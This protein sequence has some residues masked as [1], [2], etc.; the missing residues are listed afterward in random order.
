MRTLIF[1]ILV[2]VF[3]NTI[4][5]QIP[6]SLNYQA[7]ARNNQGVA[8]S[9]QTIRIRL[10]IVRGFNTLYT[11]TRQVTTNLL[12]LFNVQIGSPGATSTSG[13]FGDINWAANTPNPT[14]L[15]VE[16]DLTNTN[17][18]TDMGTQ[19]FNTVPTSFW[20]GKSIEVVNL[21]GRYIDP[22]TVPSVNSKLVWNGYAWTPTKN[23]TTIYHTGLAINLPAGGGSAPW[24][25]VAT[26][27]SGSGLPTVTVTGTEKII[28]NW[29]AALGHAYSNF[30]PILAD[31]CY[32]Q[33]PSGSITSFSSF[34]NL[35]FPL[36]IP[37]NTT[38]P[39]TSV[40]VNGSA[41]LTAGQYRVGMCVKNINGTG[42]SLNNNGVFT[43]VV[44][45]KY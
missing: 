23:D 17:I 4:Y 42:A 21:A 34:H 45:V 19:V 38:A 6:Q 32:Q 2:L 30:I 1:L 3:T 13:V 8:L 11:E 40:S 24:T 25:W 9:N 16:L 44:Q 26:N 31:V 5:A 37:I 35:S 39:L 15:K 43:G 33:L 14:M 36:G 41:V 20:S 12:G 27:T 22:V 28:A 7:V 18:F 29:T 10:S